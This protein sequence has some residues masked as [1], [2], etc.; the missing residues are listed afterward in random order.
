MSANAECHFTFHRATDHP[1]AHT[2]R[3]GSRELVEEFREWGCGLQRI[4]RVITLQSSYNTGHYQGCEDEDHPCCNWSHRKKNKQKHQM[5]LD[6]EGRSVAKCCWDTG[7]ESD[8]FW[9]GLLAEGVWFVERPEKHPV[10]P[11]YSID[12]VCCRICM[13]YLSAMQLCCDIWGVT[14]HKSPT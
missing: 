14:D 7:L 11:S 4:C 12:D 9:L 1:G 5:A 2:G 3:A 10:T 6:Q 13:M 8:Q